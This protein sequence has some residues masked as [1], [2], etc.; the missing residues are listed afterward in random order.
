MSRKS[1]IDSFY[2]NVIEIVT[3]VIVFKIFEVNTDVKKFILGTIIVTIKSI[4][5]KLFRNEIG[6]LIIIIVTTI[7]K[8]FILK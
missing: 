6:K 5:I 8:E 3:R 7:Q 4:N 1:N 2:L